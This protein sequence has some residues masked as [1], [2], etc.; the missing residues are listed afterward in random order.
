LA[1][2]T[3]G[4]LATDRAVPP[5][6]STDPKKLNWYVKVSD[7]GL[8]SEIGAGGG[9]YIWGKLS[10]NDHQRETGILAGEAAIDS[11]AVDTALKYSFGR[12][13]PDYGKGSG[14]FFQHGDSF[15]SDHSALA[16]SIASVIAHEY[17]GPFTQMV[18]YGLATAV[19]S[20]R[21]L[22]RQHFP[23]DVVV[24]G[25]IGWLIGRQVYR[26]HHDVEL[27]G[28]GWGSLS[29]TEDSEE[30]RER[31]NMGSTFVPLDS[32]VYAVFDRLAALQYVNTAILGLRPW[33]RI[34][35]ARLT[36]EAEGV[37]PDGLNPKIAVLTYCNAASRSKT[38]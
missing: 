17:P 23:S 29:G 28:G 21:V 35:C 30:R 9:L 25:V 1:A 12:D 37:L 32:W 5:A 11:L 31:G 10:H 36:E 6:L 2:A 19:S 22:G 15:P 14:T 24:G 7:Y 26:A 16:W 34:E 38:A 13:R 20:S 27:G 3:A 8:Y 4:F 18:V 33:T